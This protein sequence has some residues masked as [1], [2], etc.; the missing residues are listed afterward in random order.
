MGE[1]AMEPSLEIRAVSQIQDQ[2][3]VYLHDPMVYRV[4]PIDEAYASSN[5]IE[6]IEEG[7]GVNFPGRTPRITSLPTSQSTMF[8]PYSIL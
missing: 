6:S 2:G 3:N 8:N 1:E 4:V 7:I 5:T